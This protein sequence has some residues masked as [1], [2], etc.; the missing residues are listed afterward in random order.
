MRPRGTAAELS[1]YPRSRYETR[2]ESVGAMVGIFGMFRQQA[3]CCMRTLATGCT[4]CKL[5]AV[6]FRGFVCVGAP[7]SSRQVSFG[8]GDQSAMSMMRV[9][10]QTWAC[11]MVRNQRTAAIRRCIKNRIVIRLDTC[12]THVSL[13][14]MRAAGGH[15]RTSGASPRPSFA[16]SHRVVATVI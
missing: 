1:P 8:C 10:L 16:R 15:R 6:T 14:E 5:V 7:R 4:F 9:S 3:S 2:T 12:V 13:H 11:S